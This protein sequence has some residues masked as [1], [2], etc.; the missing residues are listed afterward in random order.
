MKRNKLH[1]LCV[2]AMAFFFLQ[3]AGCL[4]ED[5]IDESRFGV[6]YITIKDIPP[7][8]PVHNSNAQPAQTY[9]IYINISDSD[10][11]T[12]PP[13]AKGVA[14]ISDGILQD[15]GNY[16]VT[17]PLQN[18][19]PVDGEPDY[20]IEGYDNP[21]LGTGPWSGTAFFFSVMISPQNTSE[22]G[23]NAVWVI[24]GYDLNRA[25][26]NMSWNVRPLNQNFR[27]SFLFNQLNLGPK[28]NALYND[29]IVKDP[30]IT[31]E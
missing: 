11:E 24:A 29:I 6:G 14:R 3:I 25:K 28:L 20:G 10:K 13:K 12:D 26:Q 21:N 2:T 31:T 5:E 9:K 23:V 19:N 22:H 1:A 16:T 7:E 17:I 30:H 18:R 8:I 27:S 15:D 4:V